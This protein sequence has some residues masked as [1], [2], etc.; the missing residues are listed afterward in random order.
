MVRT[1]IKLSDL[2]QNEQVV[3][4]G[5]PDNSGVINADLIRVLYNHQNTQAQ[6]QSGGQTQNA[7][8]QTQNTAT[9]D[10]ECNSLSRRPRRPQNQ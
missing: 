6:P 9:A 1:I 7:Q 3:V 5:N 10:T 4:V 2:Q 8:P